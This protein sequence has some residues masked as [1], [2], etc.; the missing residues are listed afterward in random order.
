MEKETALWGAP[1]TSGSKYQPQS[2]FCPP[3]L[4]LSFSAISHM[5]AG[6]AGWREIRDEWQEGPGT[7]SWSRAGLLTFLPATIPTPPFL[8][9]PVLNICLF[10]VPWKRL[11]SSHW[12][13]LYVLIVLCLVF[14]LFRAAPS[15]YGCFQARGPIGA[16]AAGLH[17]SHSHA[18]SELHLRS[19]PQLT[20]TPDP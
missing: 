18:G 3:N 6:R 15:A 4:P 14:C 10:I 7:A 11:P 17:H 19:T 2:L 1:R 5:A 13:K 8:P 20:A 9:F 12:L 16:T